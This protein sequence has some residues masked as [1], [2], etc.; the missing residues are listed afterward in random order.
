M[1]VTVSARGFPKSVVK[2]F[3]AAE[4]GDYNPIGAGGKPKRYLIG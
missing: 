1:T 4:F 3:L 2:E